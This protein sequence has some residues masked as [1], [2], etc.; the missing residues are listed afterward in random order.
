MQLSDDVCAISLLYF[1][2]S[3][4]VHPSADEAV[5]L[6]VPAAQAVT[7]DPKPVYP[8]SAV[9]SFR[10]SDAARLAELSGQELHVSDV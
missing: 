5:L 1:P 3:Q 9:Q 2:A 4:L 6:N 8:A 7:L 10:E